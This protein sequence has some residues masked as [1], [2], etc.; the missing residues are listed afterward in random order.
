MRAFCGRLCA[1]EYTQVVRGLIDVCEKLSTATVESLR[2]DPAV[3]PWFPIV[4][5]SA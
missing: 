1:E 2:W 4:A 5:S 3:H